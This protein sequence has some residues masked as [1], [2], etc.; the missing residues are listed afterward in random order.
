MN[1]RISTM[2]P[3]RGVAEDVTVAVAGETSQRILLTRL[4]LRN[5]EA[6]MMIQSTASQTMVRAN[7]QTTIRSLAQAPKSVAE[8]E[9]LA[10]DAGS[11]E[12]VEGER[13]QKQ[14]V[15]V[16]IQSYNSSSNLMLLSQAPSWNRSLALCTVKRLDSLRPAKVLT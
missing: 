13:D 4:V 6:C 1:H 8:G 14:S 9:E 10:A 3:L 5:Q 12:G 15:S 11:A 2:A 7:R 16:R